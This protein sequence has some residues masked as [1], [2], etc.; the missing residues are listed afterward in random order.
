[1]PA[2]YVRPYSK[3]QKNDLRDAEAISKRRNV[4]PIADMLGTVEEASADE[5]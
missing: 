1:M 4:Q 3:S 5:Q 2:K